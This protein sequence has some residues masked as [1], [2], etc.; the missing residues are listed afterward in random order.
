MSKIKEASQFTN[1]AWSTP[2]PIGADDANIDITSATTNPTDST[3]TADG[4][5]AADVTASSGDTDAS[6]W[7]KFNRFR[8]RVYNSFSSL[9]GKTLATAYTTSS[10]T[11]KVYSASV[12]NSYMSNVVG[13]SGTTAPNAGTVASQLSSLNDNKAPRDACIKPNLL[14]N[15]Y[16]GNPVNQRYQTSYSNAGYTIDRWKLTSGSVEVISGGITLNGTLVQILETSIGQTVT[17]S[18][19]LSNGSMITP[20]YDDNTKT[21]TLTA[22]GQTIK[23]VKLELGSGQTLAHNEGTNANPVWVLNEIPDYGEQLLRCQRYLQTLKHN[24][25]L[26][27]ANRLT[28]GGKT[29]IDFYYRLCPEMHNIPSFSNATWKMSTYGGTGDVASEYSFS[30]ANS[31]KTMLNVRAI[32]SSADGLTDAQLYSSTDVYIS[33]E[34]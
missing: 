31:A 10:D 21:F 19:L 6:A 7:T 20:T 18:A 32:K 1:G 34:P 11:N 23:A 13:Y 24:L 15:W 2:T 17:A 25:R 8:K 33:C 30:T 22:T 29:Y 9:A 5:I 27:S 4:L 14:D 26:R 12:L 28:T 3:A 16:F